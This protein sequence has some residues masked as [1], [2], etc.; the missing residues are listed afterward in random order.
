MEYKVCAPN[1]VLLW[2]QQFYTY[3]TVMKM[4]AAI[5]EISRGDTSDIKTSILLTDGK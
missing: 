5:V 2:A 1:T 3:H 4:E